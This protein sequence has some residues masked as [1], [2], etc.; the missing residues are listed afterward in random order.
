[1]QP[2]LH[3]QLIEAYVRDWAAAA[4]AAAERTTPPHHH[5][6]VK[7]FNNRRREPPE[8][9]DRQILKWWGGLPPVLQQRPYA[10]EEIAAQLSGKYQD[11]PATRDVAKALRCLGWRAL[12]D[13][14]TS[15]RGRRLW[16]APIDS[17]RYPDQP[18]GAHRKSK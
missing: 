11:R 12:R 6:T 14:T 15:G 16:C 3:H 7:S 17:P 4:I 8:P 10:V 18:D 2:P 13:W 5:E 9:L 1:M